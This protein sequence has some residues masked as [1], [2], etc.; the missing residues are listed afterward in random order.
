MS[1]QALIKF[2]AFSLVFLFFSLSFFSL[3]SSL[4][5]S[6]SYIQ[7]RGLAAKM[8]FAVYLIRFRVPTSSSTLDT[9]YIVFS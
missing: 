6:P 1:L 5:S 8:Q 7:F 9:Y 4:Y 3:S 2:T